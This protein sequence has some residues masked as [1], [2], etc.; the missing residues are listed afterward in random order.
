MKI[1]LIILTLVAVFFAINSCTTNINEGKINSTQP[2]D[3]IIIKP[4]DPDK[5][6][7]ARVVDLPLGKIGMPMNVKEV[8]EHRSALHGK[9][10]TVKGYVVEAILGEDACPAAKKGENS[11][12]PVQG[13][14]GRPRIFLA[15]KTDAARD[16]QYDLMILVS[17]TEDSY[18]K[19]QWVEITGS[20][21]ASKVAVIVDMVVP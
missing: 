17:E 4:V 21:S 10:I 13:G 7:L 18:K 12:V 3:K 9:Q 5:D 16:T 8:I 2:V 6:G 15:D 14:C 19:G 20:V 1:V 11:L